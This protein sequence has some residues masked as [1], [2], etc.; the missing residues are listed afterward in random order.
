MVAQICH[1]RSR[2]LTVPII[3]ILLWPEYNYYHALELSKVPRWL[4]TYNVMMGT[5]NWQLS[6]ISH[7]SFGN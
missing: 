3:Y 2:Q 5:E 6:A 7:Q 1:S 4:I